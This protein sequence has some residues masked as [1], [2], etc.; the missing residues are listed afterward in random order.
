M[1]AD[2]YLT[3]EDMA[4]TAEL[5]QISTV[6]PLA[7]TW[8]NLLPRI[9]DRWAN[10]MLKRQPSRYLTG[11][12][13]PVDKELVA[14]DCSLESGAIPTALVGGAYIRTGKAMYV[15]VIILSDAPI[16]IRPHDQ[17]AHQARSPSFY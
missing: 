5:Q 15:M 17:A 6:A 9:A 7:P 13:A 8:S 12:Y 11:N 4:S 1:V 14:T 16:H 2:S 10:W 3:N